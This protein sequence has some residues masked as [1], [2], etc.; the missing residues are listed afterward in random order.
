[1]FRKRNEV[2]I[3]TMR[4][5]DL[6]WQNLE[7]EYGRREIEKPKPPRIRKRGRRKRCDARIK[8][9]AYMDKK[10]IHRR[11]SPRCRQWALIGKERCRMHGGLST[12]PKTPEGKARVLAAL[13][14]GRRRWIER[15]HAEGKKAPGGRKPKGG[16]EPAGG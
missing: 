14:E 7:R 10:G 15:L 8:Q 1:M 2:L 6:L 5:I 11:R 13:V 12:G 4:I 9:F 3:P 16:G